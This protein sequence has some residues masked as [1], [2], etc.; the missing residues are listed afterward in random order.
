MEVERISSIKDYRFANKPKEIIEML[1][2]VVAFLLVTF[3]FCRN[4]IDFYKIIE[5]KAKIW[6]NTNVRRTERRLLWKIIQ[7][8][9]L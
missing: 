3:R 4:L 7:M 1:S 5:L 8:E 2:L 6:Y 9:I